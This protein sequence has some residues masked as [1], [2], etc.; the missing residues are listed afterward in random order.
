MKRLCMLLALCG[1]LAVGCS[2]WD[3]HLTG[4]SGKPSGK[5]S[6]DENNTSDVV[7]DVESES[8]ITVNV[9]AAGGNVDIHLST[10]I[11]YS[12]NIAEEAQSWVSLAESRADVREEV[13]TFVVAPN[14]E[15]ATR[16]ARVTF[17]DAEGKVLYNLNLSQKGSVEAAPFFNLTGET[18]FSFEAEG[19]NVAVSIETNIDFEV[20][21][22]EDAAAWLGVA[23]ALADRV[24]F[25]ISANDSYESRSAE[26]QFI[27]VD[28]AV[29][30]TIAFSQKGLVEDNGDQ[31]FNFNIID[32]YVVE[33]TGGNI[34][35]AVSTNIDYKVSIPEAAQAWITLSETRGEVVT[36]VLT[37]VV[38]ANNTSEERSAEV[39][40]TDAADV[41]LQSFTIT[42]KGM[43]REGNIV[44]AD[45]D[46][47]AVCVK[48]YDVDGDGE[49]SYQEAEWVTYIPNRFFS[50][51]VSSNMNTFDELKY[52]I[53]VSS[54]HSEAFYSC[55]NLTSITFPDS[56]QSIGEMAFYGCKGL[57]TFNMPKGVNYIYSDAFRG[58]DNLKRVYVSDLT[59]WCK[60]EFENAYA[61]P[62][63]YGA[64]LFVNDVFITELTIP[65]GITAIKAFAFFNCDSLKKLTIPAGVTSIGKS[66]FNGCD[67]LS[68]VSLPNT[69]TSIGG[70][71]FCNCLGLR[72]IALPES[73]TTIGSYAFAYSG[74]TTITI[75]AS[76]TSIADSAFYDCGE[77]RYVYCTATTPPTISGS[78]AF[79]GNASSRKIYVPTASVDAYKKAAGWSSYASSI[80]GY[81]F[82]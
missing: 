29:L 77:L 47:K 67:V 52:F 53:N 41:A 38:A 71:V 32:S 14:E 51:S 28:G 81:D 37:F 12:V 25:A 10:N 8:I 68:E 13:V 55:T 45:E 30:A 62:L 21:V 75:P 31:I 61:N 72:E 42:Q 65:T 16:V 20:V 60:V 35:I 50:S 46:V 59:A 79:Y 17:N 48:K 22:A 24:V 6:G 23:E 19:G 66:A 26:V 33:H 56:L 40:F 74:L 11:E 64:Y 54:I 73:L 80:Y 3:F 15:M 9:D 2:E 44:F 49:V 76:V 1:V 4:G 36:E 18:E 69:L 39:L 82:N 27:D 70:Y 5:P 57:T 43:N 34:M 78:N 58:C 7:F 63:Y